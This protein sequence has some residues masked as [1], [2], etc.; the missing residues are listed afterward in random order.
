M[1]QHDLKK[2][3]DVCVLTDVIKHVSLNIQKIRNIVRHLGNLQDKVNAKQ[4]TIWVF[5]LLIMS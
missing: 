1:K 5:L 2:G 3:L 4:T